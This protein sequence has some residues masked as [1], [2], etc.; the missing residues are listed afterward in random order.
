MMKVK[1]IRRKLYELNS[2]IVY[3]TNEENKLIQF[4]KDNL[5]NENDAIQVP[6]KGVINNSISALLM[7]RMN[8]SGIATHFI[9]KLNMREQLIHHLEIFPLRV[10]ISNVAHGKYVKDFAIEEGYVFKQPLLEFYVD[11]ASINEQQ[12]IGIGL[13]NDSD[14]VEL[15]TQS[16]RV[17]DFLRGLLAASKL[18]LVSCK[19][20]FGHMIGDDDDIGLVL[21]DELTPD[22]CRIWDMHSNKKMDHEYVISNPD[23]AIA[24]YKEIAKRLK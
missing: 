8:N 23:K 6:G 12:A 9:E 21:A 19:L 18:R 7:D 10:Q 4:F 11:N 13:V 2:K 3:Q 24:M 17:N 5:Q 1:Y 16:C 14:L 22:N 20:T 15:K